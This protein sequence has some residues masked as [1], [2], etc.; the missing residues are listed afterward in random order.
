MQGIS[1]MD[2][3]RNKLGLV[4]LLHVR[5]SK[6]RSSQGQKIP[7]YYAFYIKNCDFRFYVELLACQILQLKVNIYGLVLSSKRFFNGRFEV[8][9]SFVLLSLDR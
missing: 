6:Y 7:Q 8:V 1:F 5:K 2:V 4:F 3:L 9:I